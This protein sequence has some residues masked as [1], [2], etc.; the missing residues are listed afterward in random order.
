MWGPRRELTG[1]KLKMLN[2]KKGSIKIIK[3]NIVI[4]L[5]LK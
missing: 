2:K 3:Q 4:R 5:I 1:A